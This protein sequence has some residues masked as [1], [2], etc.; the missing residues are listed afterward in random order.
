MK[1]LRKFSLNQEPPSDNSEFS[2]LDKFFMV[3]TASGFLGGTILTLL[4]YYL[5]GLVPIVPAIFF[6][7]GISS[8][9]YR[10]MGGI[11]PDTK[12][13]VGIVTLGGTLASLVATIWLFNAI[14]ESQ[15][16]RPD[17]QLLL[18]PTENSLLAL[19]KESG[20]PVKVKVGVNST[21]KIKNPERTIDLP[22]P[23]VLD[24]IK[25][26]CRSGEGFCKEPDLKVIFQKD[27]S[28]K[29]REAKVCFNQNRLVGYPLII[30]DNTNS[31]AALVSV[32]G[33]SICRDLSGRPMLIKIGSRSAQ[34]ILG[35]QTQGQGKATIASLKNLLLD[36]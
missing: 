19:E 29:P 25:D 4:Y 16:D 14:F 10:F 1:S 6:G 23:L 7:S 8:L 2:D 18:R 5:P 12:I 36:D 30:Q 31:K 20:T 28:L 13:Q 9:V 21:A 26:I 15:L 17:I 27:T 3:V 32:S 33:T 22:S 35:S 24:R 34:N 11:K